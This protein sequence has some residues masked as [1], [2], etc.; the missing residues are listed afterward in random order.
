MC[1][2][3]AQMDLGAQWPG[4]ESCLH[5]C[6]LCDLVGVAY[7]LY[8]YLCYLTDKIGI[9]IISLIGLL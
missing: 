2:L 8:E 7:L 6:Y 1:W 9:I 3:K 4:F 5:P